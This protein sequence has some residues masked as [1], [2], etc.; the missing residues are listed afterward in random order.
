[1]RTLPCLLTIAWAVVARGQGWCPPGAEWHYAYS[2]IG[3][4]HGY[5]HITP[6]A[7][8]T[9]EGHVCTTLNKLTTAWNGS[10]VV[11]FGRPPEWTY[12][13]SGVVYVR[14]TLMQRFD[15]LFNVRADPGDSWRMPLHPLQANHP[16]ADSAFMLVTDTGTRVIDNV[17]LRW[18]RVRY[19]MRPEAVGDGYFDTLVER[20]GP[21][22]TYLLPMDLCA[23]AMDINEGGPLRC[24][25]DNE[26]QYQATDQPNCT[27]LVGVGEL[28]GP[29]RSFAYP[30]PGREQV[31]I[32]MD[33]AVPADRISVH[34]GSGRLFAQVDRPGARVVLDT[35]GWPSGCYF[36]TSISE[37][38]A[39]S[40]VRWIKL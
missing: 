26:I 40:V 15:T 10:Q 5:V 16:C 37:K 19:L 33:G 21:L 6:G 9:I 39:R 8:T 7:D 17:P 4:Q 23:L 18:L 25:A 20:I 38:G 32:Q 11:Q 30:D 24:Y 31:T 28:A 36:I 34:D 35:G 12:A 27:F 22:H 29:S 13:E 3:G 14:N 1:M 2:D